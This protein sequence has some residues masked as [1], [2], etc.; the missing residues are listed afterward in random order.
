MC[1]SH[2]GAALW[3]DA[4]R[5]CVENDHDVTPTP[6]NG[7]PVYGMGG[8]HGLGGRAGG[9]E[10]TSGDWNGLG[11]REPQP[12]FCQGEGRGFESRRPLHLKVLVSGLFDGWMGLRCCGCAHGLPMVCPWSP[13]RSV[14]TGSLRQRGPDTWELRVYLGTNVDPIPTHR[15]PVRSV[16]AQSG[17]DVK[18]FENVGGARISETP[19]VPI[20]A[21]TEVGS[22]PSWIVEMDRSR[23][24]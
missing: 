5:V 13:Y 9:Q 14:M 18:A 24:I 21:S 6:G 7:R 20:S 16:D 1:Q 3:C 8:L 15:K 10:T 11:G 23:S 19:L 12:F 22:N 2:S 17:C 4:P